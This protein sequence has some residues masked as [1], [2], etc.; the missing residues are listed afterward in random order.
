VGMLG[1][2]ALARGAPQAVARAGTEA[3]H[4]AS[5]GSGVPAPER[6]RPY[7]NEG[8]MGC[9]RRR[10]WSY[11]YMMAAA[12]GWKGQ[13]REA[14]QRGIRTPILLLRGIC[15]INPLSYRDSAATRLLGKPWLPAGRA[16]P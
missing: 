9:L 2:A 16:P 4:A 11:G 10:E 6:V 8:D 14:R 12:R 7:W 15:S 13:P 3:A 5:Q 1:R